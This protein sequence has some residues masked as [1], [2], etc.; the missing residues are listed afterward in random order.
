ML[1]RKVTARISTGPW[2]A[3]GTSAAQAGDL[4]P[5]QCRPARVE[6]DLAQV[7]ESFVGVLERPSP[8]Q[9]GDGLLD[10]VFGSLSVID[11]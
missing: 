3:S 7:C 8:V 2:A 10:Y 4:A 5:A 1:L 11:H 6:H 9:L